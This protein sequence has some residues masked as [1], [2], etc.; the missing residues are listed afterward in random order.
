MEFRKTR[1]NLDISP[2]LEEECKLYTASHY[3][4]WTLVNKSQKQDDEYKM[5]ASVAEIYE[6]SRDNLHNPLNIEGLNFS[7][8]CSYFK[9]YIGTYGWTVETTNEDDPHQLPEHKKMLFQIQHYGNSE[10][11]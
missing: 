11:I 7:Q 3:M 6:R 2:A 10:L 5:E 9:D 4:M 1:K 8:L